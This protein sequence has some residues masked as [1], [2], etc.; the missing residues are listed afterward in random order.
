MPLEVQHQAGC[1][2]GEHYPEPI[3]DRRYTRRA[4]LE[5]YREAG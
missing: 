5:R 2:I 4:A 1:V 3:I